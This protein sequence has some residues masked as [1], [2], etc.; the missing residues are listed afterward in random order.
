[1]KEEEKEDKDIAEQEEMEQGEEEGG[2]GIRIGGK[3]RRRREKD[4][5]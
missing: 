2:Q 3:C 4:R 5:R 1:V